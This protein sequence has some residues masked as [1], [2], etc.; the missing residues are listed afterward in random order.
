MAGPPKTGLSRVNG[1]VL[2]VANG[3]NPGQAGPNHAE[4]GR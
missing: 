2:T 4:A 1:R 3:A